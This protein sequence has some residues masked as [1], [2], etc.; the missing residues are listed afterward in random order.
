MSASPRVVIVSRVTGFAA[1]PTPAYPTCVLVAPDSFKGTYSASE[2]ATA[3]GRGLRAAGWEVD[4]CPVADGGEGTLDVLLLAL[5]G[6]TITVDVHDPLGRPVHAE[7]ALLDDGVTAIVELARASGLDLVS[8]RERDPEVASSAGTGELVVAA[9]EAGARRILLTVGGSATS[10]G[11]DGA[12]TAIEAAGG[13]RGAQLVV[14]CDVTTPFE[15]AGKVF[16]PQKGADAAAVR[17]I[18]AR[19]ER[20]A[21][22]LPRDPRGVPMTGAAGGLSGG[23]WATF[24]ARLERGAP[25]VLDAVGFDQRMRAARAV[26]VG[27]GSID[28]QTLAGKVAAEAAVRCRQAGV[29]AHAVVGRNRLEPFDA[30]I[31][32]LQLILEAGTPAAFEAA[33]RQLAEAL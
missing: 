17:R 18:T 28:S 14:L 12:I 24:D 9:V 4:P 1:V 13:L 26:V 32:D 10:D 19:L 6:E 22:R 21:A 33:G 25:F 16:G 3:I 8:P 29:P 7:L 31:L 20:M 2:V 11:G 27:E 30:R 15:L 23:L 5:G